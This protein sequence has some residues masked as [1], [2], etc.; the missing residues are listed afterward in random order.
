MRTQIWISNPIIGYEQCIAK[1]VV[2][3]LPNRE[4]NSWTFR[5]I[6]PTRAPLRRTPRSHACKNHHMI[7]TGDIASRFYETEATREKNIKEAQQSSWEGKKPQLHMSAH[8]LRQ[9][10]VAQSANQ[11]RPKNRSKSNKAIKK[12]ADSNSS[13]SSRQS[14]NEDK[15]QRIWRE[16]VH[17]GVR[18]WRE[19][20]PEGQSFWPES[21][22]Q[23]MLPE[24]SR[25]A[26]VKPPDEC[27]EVYPS[28]FG[29]Y[30]LDP[31]AESWYS[32]YSALRPRE[33][34]ASAENPEEIEYEPS[35]S[36]SADFSDT[37]SMCLY[38]AL[39]K[40]QSEESLEEV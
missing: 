38:K 15:K 10:P 14:S 16:K 13:G 9:S 35:E 11:K 33:A 30:Y 3:R 40:N 37:E 36:D 29:F 17:K 31:Q 2:V 6:F 24:V 19:K 4:S 27:Y 25:D 21:H 26:Q 23:R 32:I 12:P 20:V 18:I 1:M 39:L 28:R 34:R 5:P 22:N 8:V 7:L